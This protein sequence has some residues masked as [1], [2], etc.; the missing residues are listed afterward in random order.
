MNSTRVLRIVDPV[1]GISQIS[2]FPETPPQG[3]TDLEVRIRHFTEI[4]NFGFLGYVLAHEINQEAL[5]DELLDICINWEHFVASTNDLMIPGH[6]LMI[7]DSRLQAIIDDLDEKSEALV[8]EINRLAREYAT[9]SKK[10]RDAIPN[11]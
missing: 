7:R 2:P 3:L 1:T 9:Q 10:Q 8:I 4:E 11:V 5:G 6:P